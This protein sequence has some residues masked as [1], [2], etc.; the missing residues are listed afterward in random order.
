MISPKNGV[1]VKLRGITEVNPKLFSTHCPPHRLILAAKEGQR[2]LPND[3]EKIIYD[4]LFFFKDSPVRHKFK[5]LKEIVELDSPH[6]SI[7]KYHRVQ[8][9]SLADCVARVVQL[10]PLLVRYF[11]EQALD[12]ANR[13]R[14]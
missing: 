6:V 11:E 9:L 2:E 10:L 13:D 3:V 12:T 7:V 1:L 5:K 14:C 8:W 4:T